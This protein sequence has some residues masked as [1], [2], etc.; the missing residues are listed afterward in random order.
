LG[1]AMVSDCPKMDMRAVVAVLVLL[2]VAMVSVLVS[3]DSIEP[4]DK[5]GDWYVLTDRITLKVEGHSAKIKLH[6][7]D[8]ITK[9]L[10]VSFEKLQEIDTVSS[11][12]NKKTSDLASSDFVWMPPVYEL[13]NGA[14]TTRIVFNAT[15]TVD[16]TRVPLACVLN[17]FLA[18]GTVTYDGHTYTVSKNHVKFSVF[19]GA[20]PFASVNNSLQ[21]AMQLKVKDAPYKPDKISDKSDG[22]AVVKEK[23][24]KL[25]SFGT[26]DLVT[27]AILDGIST[28]VQA[29]TWGDKDK[30]GARL[31]FPYYQST[32]AYD[33]TMGVTSGAIARAATALVAPITLFAILSLSLSLSL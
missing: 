20:W 32:L 12:V 25:D 10:E 6:V 18:S 27:T 1:V 29:D 28:T 33:P 11:D 30:S 2:G 22:S 23:T 3:A 16:G 14:N 5:T 19:I 21:F 26:F 9:S 31:T 8:D 24:M 13:V 4:G 17:L 7:K 15:V